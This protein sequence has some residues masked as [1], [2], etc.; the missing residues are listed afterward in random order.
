MIRFVLGILLQRHEFII[1]GG[2]IYFPE[3]QEISERAPRGIIL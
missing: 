1:N 3:L 2:Y